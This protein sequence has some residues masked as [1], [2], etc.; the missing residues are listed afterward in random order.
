[1][2][3]LSYLFSAA[4]QSPDALLVPA[5]AT[6]SSA[7]S[8]QLLYR[9]HLFPR[10]LYVLAHPPKM[11]SRLELASFHVLPWS[12]DILEHPDLQAA[13]GEFP[14]LQVTS[15][16]QLLIPTYLLQQFLNNLITEEMDPIQSVASRELKQYLASSSNTPPTVS[17][18]AISRLLQYR[19][20]DV[21]VWRHKSA[22]P[23]SVLARR[24]STSL[25]P[26]VSELRVNTLSFSLPFT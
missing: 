4:A 18:Q 10:P 3:Q 15:S 21:G 19:V 2:L 7:A 23:A 5:I 26:A 16:F 6:I 22:K 25:P 8:L 20:L 12:S 17:P 1:M 11:A 13:A 14:D 9:I 24:L